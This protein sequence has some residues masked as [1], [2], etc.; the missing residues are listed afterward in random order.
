ME[1]ELDE[2]II[3]EIDGNKARVIKG[4]S[5]GIWH[6]FTTEDSP[7]IEVKAILPNLAVIQTH[8]SQ[9]HLE[10][11]GLNITVK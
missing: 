1:I 7:Q 3:L 6:Q 9:Y 11:D 8:D 10:I 2:L 5:I 4:Q